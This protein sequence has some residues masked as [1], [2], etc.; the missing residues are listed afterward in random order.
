MMSGETHIVSLGQ[1]AV[2]HGAETLAVLGL[3]SCVAVILHDP[4]AHIG[5]LVHVV[6]PSISLARDRSNPSR[7]AETAVPYLLEQLQAAGALCE[8]LT[9][10]LVG[11][12]SMFANLIPAGSMH[13]GHR[14]VMACRAALR[15]VQVRVTGEAV[16]GEAGRSVWFEA[17]SGRVL[18][19]TVGHEP[20]EL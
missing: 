8:R 1:S 3:G 14:N 17:A 11:G 10:R 12:A 7:F 20:V 4:E 5:G 19:R 2:S 18:V 9:G 15:A 16:G 6:L 13:M